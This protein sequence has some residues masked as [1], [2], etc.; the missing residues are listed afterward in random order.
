MSPRIVLVAM[1]GE[2]K[3]PQAFSQAFFVI[4]FVFETLVPSHYEKTIN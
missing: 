4:D 2:G 1:I 3:T